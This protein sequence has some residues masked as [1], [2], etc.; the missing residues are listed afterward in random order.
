MP[1]AKGHSGPWWQDERTGAP[2]RSYPTS[3]NPVRHSH[4]TAGCN[5]RAQVGTE[6]SAKLLLSNHPQSV[7]VLLQA[8]KRVETEGV[9]R[10]GKGGIAPER[11]LQRPWLALA[12]G[13]TA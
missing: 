11:H 10:F 2:S 5:N 8:D 9:W 6:L 13:N 4:A 3:V 7:A 1:E 12:Q